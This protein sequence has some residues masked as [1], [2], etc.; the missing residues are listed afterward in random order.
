MKIKQS[1]MKKEICVERLNLSLSKKSIDKYRL[2]FLIVLLLLITSISSLGQQ[3]PMFTQYMFNTLSVNP[4]YAGTRN[5][6]NLNSLTRIQWVGIDGAPKTISLALHAPI[7]K[8][9]IG[10]GFSI[11][12]DEVGPVRNTYIAINY[13]YRIKISESLTLSMG[14][15]GGAN[16]YTLGL[17]NLEVNEQND[18]D[19]QNNERKLVPNVGMGFYLSSNRYYVGN[20]ARKLVETVIDEKYSAKGNEFRRHYYIIG[21]FVFPINSNWIFKPTILTK[22]VEGAPL[23]ND[24]SLQFLYNERIWFGAMYRIGDAAGALLAMKINKQ[25]TVGYAYDFALSDLSGLNKGTHEIML[26]FDFTGT[27]AKKVISPRYF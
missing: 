20:L 11:V 3:E 25:L 18:P 24:I 6:L 19:F 7:N 9:K 14:I 12:D 5:A 26:S 1:V 17:T 16:N 27:P 15:K 13:A 4:A 21:G 8:K 22:A 23:S 2:L 10:V